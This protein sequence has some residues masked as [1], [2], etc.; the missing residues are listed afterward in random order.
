VLLGRGLLGEEVAGAVQEGYWCPARSVPP[1]HST[2]P[3]M[4]AAAS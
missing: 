4:G 3:F 2:D 1:R